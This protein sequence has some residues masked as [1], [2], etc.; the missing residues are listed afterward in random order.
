MQP[1]GPYILGGFCLGA[2]LAYE[3][4][5]QLKAAA[6]E[7][8]LL[9]LVDPPNPSHNPSRSTIAERWAHFRYLVK[10]AEWLGP[11]TSIIYFLERLMKLI[12]QPWRRPLNIP[13]DHI[14]QELIKS[15]V[16]SYRPQAYGGRVLLFL[17]I[18]T[19]PH[20]KSFLGWQTVG[21]SNL[22]THYVGMHHREMMEPE[23]ARN[24]ADVLALQLEAIESGNP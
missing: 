17:P 18:E 6:E 19:H 7:V 4:A 11:R 20:V 12:P 15:A 8:R 10:R 5:S 9:V 16:F 24:I 23:N 2:V 3:I 21:T 22:Q 13:E 1:A 14:S